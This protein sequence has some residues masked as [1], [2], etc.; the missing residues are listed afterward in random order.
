MWKIRLMTT[1]IDYQSPNNPTLAL[2]RHRACTALLISGILTILGGIGLCILVTSLAISEWSR[3]ARAA[4]GHVHPAPIP[5]WTIMIAASVALIPLILGILSVI[6]TGKISRGS[7]TAAVT[8]LVITR[9]QFL[10]MCAAPF[11]FAFGL[12]SGFRNLDA[13]ACFVAGLLALG[14]ILQAIPEYHLQRLLQNDPL[15]PPTPQ[16]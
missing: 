6:C 4:V 5:W 10:L 13:D 2:I 14:A 9:I 16:T 12:S 3:R 11:M 1:S 15:T 7:R 8:A